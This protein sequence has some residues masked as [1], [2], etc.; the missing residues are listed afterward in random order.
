MLA[1]NKPM[2]SV[3]EKLSEKINYLKPREIEGIFAILLEKP[4]ISNNKLVRITGLPKETLRDFKSAISFLLKTAED[5]SIYIS[6]E[7][8]EKLRLDNPRP[9]EWRLLRLNNESATKQ[10]KEIRKKYKLKPNRDLDQFFA[11]ERTSV[12]KAL[13]LDKKGL[14]DKTRI[15]LLGDDDLVSI[16]LSLIAPDS[17]KITTFDADKTLLTAITSIYKDLGKENIQMVEYDARK[18]LPN[19][20]K[21]QFHVVVTDP[22]YTP[23]GVTLFLN[24]AIELVRGNDKYIFLYFGT[25]NKTPEKTLKIQEIINQM[26]LV[27]ED[28]IDKFAQYKGAESI[29]S[30]S[31]VYIL[32]TTPFTAPGSHL[33]DYS[34]L[35]THQLSKEDKFP[36]VD[37]V[38]FKL[39]SVPKVVVE[40]KSSLFKAL[41]EFCNIH[42]LKVVDEKVTKFKNGGLTITYILSNSNLVVHT[43]PELNAIHL[44][45]ITCSPIYNKER[46]GETLAKLFLAK[47]IEI[48]S[49]E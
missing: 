36:Y 12:A 17:I 3:V 48:R 11:T 13:L 31:S 29:G 22:P 20:Y 9:Y 21:G 38:V 7:Y 32:K 34:Q 43:W 33:T 46:L 25:S 5:D 2:Q 28:K 16:T 37:H 40:S 39:Y 4:G 44:D 41:G 24:R 35:Y 6:D 45:L 49:I 42:K 1:Y 14:L 10:L 47:K 19:M 27:I 15:A 30:N 8:V 18:E 23:A 26:G